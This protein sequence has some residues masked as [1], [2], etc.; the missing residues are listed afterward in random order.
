MEVEEFCFDIEHC[1]KTL[2]EK[3]LSFQKNLIFLY[4]ISDFRNVERV[5]WP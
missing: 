5:I 1:R 3:T 4:F 2:V